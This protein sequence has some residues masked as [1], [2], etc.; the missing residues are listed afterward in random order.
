LNFVG[1]VAF[2]DG[3]HHFVVND[4]FVRFF[5]ALLTT[6]APGKMRSTSSTVIPG[7]LSTQEVTSC[8]SSSLS[9]RPSLRRAL[10]RPSS[11]TLI[12][13][14]SVSPS[15]ITSFLPID[16]RAPFLFLFLPFLVSVPCSSLSVPDF[17][18]FPFVLL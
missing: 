4:K 9:L 11:K 3:K 15:F 1:A 6:L 5:H 12:C 10:I 16:R 13:S 14:M 8:Q 2:L 18:C 7:W 17:L